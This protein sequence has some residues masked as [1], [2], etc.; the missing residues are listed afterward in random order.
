MPAIHIS[1]SIDVDATPEK[2]YEIVSN[3]HHWRPWSPWLIAEPEAKVSV[4]EDGKYY[5]WEG[6][7]T[8]VGNMTVT[9][10][11]APSRVDYDL[12]F[13]KPWKS[14]AKVSFDCRAKSG[15]GTTVSWNM[16]TSLP[17]Y[18]FWMKN[19]MIAYLNSDYDRGLA[20]LKEYVE[21]GAVS[22]QLEF[23]GYG[24]YPGTAYVGIT[25]ATTQA[26]VGPQMNA[27]LTKLA[28]HQEE[29]VFSASGAPFSIYHKFDMVKNQ[30]NYTI[31]LPVAEAPA[32]LPAGLKA[33]SIPATRTYT[34][35]HV[36]PYKHL[37]NAWSALVMMQ[38]GKEFKVQ[39]GI[40]P[41]EVYGN[42]PGEVPD[43]E[44]ITDIHFAVK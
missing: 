16:D 27:D 32:S 2:V 7:R 22:S 24:E 19:S 1:R 43:E 13:L 23:L 34:L 44:L 30:V 9:D 28:K 17:F 36:G 18:L 11:T 14:S 31:A 8:G 42:A 3:F 21:D 35:R 33:G 4:A 29:G 25:T 26:D 15:G 39:R 10:S 38:R 12:E 6:Q 5:E 20:M 40:H 37:G 41:F